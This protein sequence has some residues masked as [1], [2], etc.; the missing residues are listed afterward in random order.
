MKIK[1]IRART[2]YDSK[3]QLTVEA[4]VETKR[5]IFKGSCPSG[6]STGRYEREMISADEA[7]DNINQVIAPVLEGMGIKQAKI[8]KKLRSLGGAANVTLPVSIAVARAGAKDL[9]LW[10]YLAKLSG[11]KEPR[12]PRPV[13]LLIEGALHGGG[14]LD[15]QELMVVFEELSPEEGLREGVRLYHELKELVEDRFGPQFTNVGLEGGLAGLEINL[16]EALQLVEGSFILDMAASHLKKD[17]YHFEGQTYDEDGLRV[18]YESLIE[19]YPLVGIED[20]FDQD[21]E[22]GW[23]SLTKEVEISII[24][25]DLTVTNEERVKMAHKKRLCNGLVVKPNQV[26]TV[27]ETMKAAQVAQKAG[28]DLFVKHRSGETNDSFIVDLAVG[29]GAEYLMAGA[30]VRGERVA[31]YNRFLEIDGQL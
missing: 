3:G 19:K 25:D 4:T 27:T 20:P 9:Y 15:V 2:I 6:I 17:K 14:S 29:L 12:L 24:G 21:D 1:N 16:E 30:P 11:N 5:G 31:K 26:G 23:A 28:W 13:I 18:L 10:S 22:E 7:A 8:D